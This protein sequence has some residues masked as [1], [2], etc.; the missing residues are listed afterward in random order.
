MPSFDLHHGGPVRC[1]RALANEQRVQGLDVTVIGGTRGRRETQHEEVA[2]AAREV[3]VPIDLLS[4]SVSSA[5]GRWLFKHAHEF[6]V[7][8]V[9]ELFTFPSVVASRLAHRRRLPV[10]L[11]PHGALMRWGLQHRR[12]RLKR[13]WIPLV[14]HRT[15][16]Q[17]AGLHFT[18]E[19][20]RAQ[21]FEV[22]APHA[23]VVAPFGLSEKEFENLAA[24]S[25]LDH[26]LPSLEGRRYLLILGR[27]DP[28]KRVDLIL[29]AF[30]HTS[31]PG[32]TLVVAGTGDEKY[33]SVL[34]AVAE[35]CG[36]SDRVFFPGFI[37][38][39]PR[40]ATI[41]QAVSI[42]QWSESESLGMAAIEAMA[43]GVPPIVSVHV[44]VAE[45]IAAR[46][47]GWVAHDTV[48]ALAVAM[49]TVARDSAARSERAEA[50]TQAACELFRART[51]A[52]VLADLYRHVTRS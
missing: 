10:V 48:E 51:S 8:H 1:V 33:R 42:V 20:E 44:G 14:E 45:T 31:D 49:E 37:R 41:A 7:I 43:A 6:D 19:L 17:A 23:A 52:A 22:V 40:L 39:K 16:R 15:I 21:S 11:S 5:L 4:F 29:R 9:H 30:A 50:A 25:S 46:K 26:R 2:S 28:V 36:I 38:D 27:L 3:S 34:M 47:A 18:S 12:P 13:A 24:A 35:Q 32:L